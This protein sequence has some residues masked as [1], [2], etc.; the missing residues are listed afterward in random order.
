M[1]ILTISGAPPWNR[2]SS[3]PK[4]S[5]Y[6][7]VCTY[8]SHTFRISNPNSK[9]GRHSTTYWT[10]NTVVPASTNNLPMIA[11]GSSG[12]GPPLL[13]RTSQLVRMGPNP[14]FCLP[15][16]FS[17]PRTRPHSRVATQVEL[18]FH[19]SIFPSE[20]G[21]LEAT[22]DEYE[23]PIWP[24]HPVTPCTPSVYSSG[25]QRHPGL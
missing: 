1:P 14:S 18:P 21:S 7:I 19:L 6:R 15:I 20:E 8:A 11:L 9:L 12:T 22:Y 23:C 4:F 3:F 25:H 13:A 16:R 10:G 24:G 5:S 17:L 2:T